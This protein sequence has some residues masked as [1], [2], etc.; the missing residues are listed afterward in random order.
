MNDNLF[1]GAAQP[2]GD[3]LTDVGGERT[4]AQ[5]QL[6]DDGLE[7]DAADVPQLLLVRQH[8]GAQ[9]LHDGLHLVLLHLVHQRA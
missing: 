4:G 6:G 9:G 3:L 1:N 7:A 2:P 8:V 5:R